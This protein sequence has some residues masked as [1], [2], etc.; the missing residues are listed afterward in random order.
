MNEL[1]VR[2]VPRLSLVQSWLCL[3]AMV[4][5]AGLAWAVKPQSQPSAAAPKLATAIPEQFGDWRVVIDAMSPVGVAQGVETSWD[6]PYDQTLMRTYVNKQGQAVMLAVAWGQR[7]R[8]DVKVHRPEVCYVAQGHVIQQEGPG[9]ALSLPGVAQRVPT[10]ALLTQERGGFEAVRYWIRIGQ[11]YGGDG[12][13]ARWY[14]LQEGLKGRVPDGILVRASTRI[15]G[16]EEAGQAQADLAKFL[17]DLTAAVS[18]AT[19][20]LRT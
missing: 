13:R 16:P 5:A 2:A 11:R 15:R 1:A 8:Q 7:Q 19:I 6:Q 20:A 12:W 18:P 9:D 17:V 10:V 3:G 14:L 4:L